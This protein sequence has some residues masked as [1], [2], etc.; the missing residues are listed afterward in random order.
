[1]DQS[2]SHLQSYQSCFSLSTGYISAL[3]WNFWSGHLQEFGCRQHLDEPEKWFD[4][5]VRSISIRT[6]ECRCFLRHERWCMQIHGW[7][8][9][10]VISS[11]HTIF[12]PESC[13]RYT[14][15]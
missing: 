6:F 13:I 10:M 9:N 3:C 7:R 14:D 8:G 2:R 4:K 5:L 1:M 15:Q 12:S 11:L